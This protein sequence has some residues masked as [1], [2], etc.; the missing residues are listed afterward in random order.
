MLDED[1]LVIAFC[2]GRPHTIVTRAMRLANTRGARSISITD[3]SMSEIAKLS[4]HHMYYSSTSPSFVRSHTGLLSVVQ[5]L[6]N[7][8]YA[9]VFARC[10]GL[11]S[12]GGVQAITRSTPA[13]LAVRMLMW[14]EATIG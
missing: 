14:A 10:Y 8:L 6:V 2:A 7:E 4:T 13:T 12:I 5:G 11:P 9:D 1:T 3:A